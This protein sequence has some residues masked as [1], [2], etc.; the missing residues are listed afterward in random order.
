MTLRQLCAAQAMVGLLA[1]PSSVKGPIGRDAWR[2]ADELLAA[3]TA[4][5]SI[6]PGEREAPRDGIAWERQRAEGLLEM[7]RIAPNSLSEYVEVCNEQR[8]HIRE[9]E[10]SF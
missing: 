4:A 8:W 5:T 9:A 10:Q 3:E 1:N 2:L 6:P 7:L